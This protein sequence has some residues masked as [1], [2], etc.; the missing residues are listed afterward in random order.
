MAVSWQILLIQLPQILDCFLL[1]SCLVLSSHPYLITAALLAPINSSTPMPQ[2]PPEFS[3]P[4]PPPQLITQQDSHRY[5]NCST[6]LKTLA[7]PVSLPLV[8]QSSNFNR[9]SHLPAVCSDM[10]STKVAVT[11]DVS[12]PMLSPS[13]PCLPPDLARHLSTLT[14]CL[15]L[16]IHSLSFRVSVHPGGGFLAPGQDHLAIK[17]IHAFLIATLA[18]TLQNLSFSLNKSHRSACRREA[19]HAP[20]ILPQARIALA[21]TGAHVFL[22]ASS[23]WTA[24]PMTL[25]QETYI[26]HNK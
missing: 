22:H 8:Q 19:N 2:P 12:S 10:L 13:S 20:T 11:Y 17:K 26:C 3:P 15:Q 9:L 14:L 25:L 1:L 21:T 23:S 24:F 7:G 5:P 18:T 4:P 6:T 16:G